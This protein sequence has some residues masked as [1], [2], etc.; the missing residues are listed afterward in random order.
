M[1][2][3]G[4]ASPD[5]ALWVL[6]EVLEGADSVTA[7]DPAVLP[8]ETGAGLRLAI[9]AT[10]LCCSILSKANQRDM[11]TPALALGNIPT[12]LT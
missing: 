3:D 8:Y 5:K 9:D 2:L 10:G 4:K 7:W 1:R 12:C 11:V 6:L